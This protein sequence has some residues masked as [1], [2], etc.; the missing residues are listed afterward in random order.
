MKQQVFKLLTVIACMLFSINVSAYDFEVDGIYYNINS[1]SDKTVEVTEG[2]E[3]YSGDIVIPSSVQ[4]Q[5]YKFCVS[6]I[7]SSAFK[8]C[9]SLR[10]ISIPNS[11][12]G[13]LYF[14]NCGCLRSVSI[15]NSITAIVTSAFENCISL[16]SI[17]IP[18]SV[19]AIGKAAFLNCQ[20]LMDIDIPKSVTIIGFGAFSG[21]SNLKSISIPNSVTV[22]GECAFQ[23]C[24]RLTS[25]I[26]P[27]SVTT[28]ESYT[29]RGSGLTG[30]TIP[31]SVIQIGSYAFNSCS[32]LA[33]I[34]IPNSVTKIGFNAFE[35]CT[36]LSMVDI[37]NSVTTIGGDVFNNCPN[38]MQINCNAT[39]P[40]TI[41]DDSF[42][43][44]QKFFAQ[45][46]VPEGCA[47]A[48]RAAEYWKDFVNIVENGKPVEPAK[49]CEAPTISYVAGK[50]KFSCNTDG[51]EYHYTLTDSDVKSDAA[52]SDGTVNLDACY[53]ITAY[54]T[55]DGYMQSEKAMATLYW[56]NA[57]LETANINK[58]QSRGVV[59]SCN[60]GVIRISG[61]D[62]G[63][64][65]M[66]YGID[67]ILMGSQPATAGEVMYAVGSSRNVVIAKIGDDAIKIAVK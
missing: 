44:S 57:N 28:I 26:I 43:S 5:N 15:P 27:N 40:P 62:E 33:S 25:I 32:N 17:I 24:S 12:T 53:K 54:A 16:R 6:G 3:K 18:N 29:F 42:T 56:I 61:L 51:A 66:F 23:N 52:Y 19:T 21:C 58:V 35:G 49:K 13:I 1:I 30:V 45:L 22:I 64:T 9:S 47:A 2:D 10:S 36:K 41:E 60:D 46:N 20:G 55:A 63:E 39:I 59:V 4:Y 14:N 38:L 65:V 8:G 67:G 37:S 31:N 50:L 48:Y 7:K 11:V 34:T